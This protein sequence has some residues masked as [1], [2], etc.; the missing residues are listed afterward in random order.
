[1]KT[2]DT[3]KEIL[4]S[5]LC[6]CYNHVNLIKY[7]L[8]GFVK[9]KT[10]FNYEVIIHDDLSTDGSQDIIREY[11]NNYPY[12][13]R[14]IYQDENQY[15]KGVNII[16]D[17][18]KPLA[19]G[20]YIALCEG[21]DYW[22]DMCKLQKQVNFMEAHTDY[23]LCVHKCTQLTLTDN[24]QIEIPVLN[25]SCDI[26][27]SEAIIQGGGFFPTCSFLYRNNFS[28]NRRW[29]TGICGDYQILLNCV[30]NGKV[31]FIADNMGV[32]TYLNSGSWSST[33]QQ[34]REKY[35]NFRMQL[36]ESLHLLDKDTNFIYSDAINKKIKKIIFYIDLDYFKNYKKLLGR[37][38]KE[39]FDEFSIRVKIAIILKAFIPRTYD[40]I[41]NIFKNSGDNTDEK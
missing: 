19:K 26:N 27:V 31:R 13:L 1:M 12:L 7:A 30:M 33:I 24:T 10:N 39:F 34:N 40:I 11:E 22:T 36:I 4:V 15:S 16:E 21:D 23:S 18:M 41:K 37:D 35:Y 38:N 3:A 8:E 20:K 9:Q 28:T 17:I 6:L 29:G 5:V 32:H 14:V 2:T 25:K